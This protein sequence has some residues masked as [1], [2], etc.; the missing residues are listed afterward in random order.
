VGT[1]V[2]AIYPGQV[3]DVVIWSVAELGSAITLSSVPAIKP[4]AVHLL[5]LF[6]WS[7]VRSNNNAVALEESQSSNQSHPKPPS[8][9]QR[10]EAAGSETDLNWARIP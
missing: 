8:P 4:L 9:S 6:S 7:E 1:D 2:N 5:R 3:V 10:D